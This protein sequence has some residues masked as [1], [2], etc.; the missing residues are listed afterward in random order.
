MELDFIKDE[1]WSVK[2]VI[3]QRGVTHACTI[4]SL[5]FFFFN[6]IVNNNAGHLF[7]Q[8]Q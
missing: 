1:H 6:V 8:E 4:H 5:D 3:K 7:L 2:D